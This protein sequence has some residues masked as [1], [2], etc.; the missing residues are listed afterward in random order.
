MTEPLWRPDEARVT[1]ANLPETLAAM[2]AAASIGAVW[3]ACSPDFGARGVVDRFGQ[4]APRL[5]FTADGYFYGGKTFDSLARV[6]EFLPELPSVERVVVLPYVNERPDLAA[7]PRAERLVDFIAG[8]PSHDI[9]FA[10]L[11]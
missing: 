9:P 7:L 6:A 5:L 8:T 11:P 3:T 10:S 4:T 1:A 2:L